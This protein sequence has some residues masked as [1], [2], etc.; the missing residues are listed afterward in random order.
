MRLAIMLNEDKGI[1]WEEVET[2]KTYAKVTEESAE[3]F[4]EW[5][6]NIMYDLAQANG[7]DIT[8]FDLEE[9]KTRFECFGLD[10]TPQ[11]FIELNNYGIM[12]DLTKTVG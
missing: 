10:A 8:P 1:Y 7:F 2:V 11:M 9:Y 6:V 5:L 3:E 12:F 4:A